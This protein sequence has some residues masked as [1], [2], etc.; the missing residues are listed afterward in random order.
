MKKIFPIL[1]NSFELN[2]DCFLIINSKVPLPLTVTKKHYDHCL[3]P[4]ILCFFRPF[5]LL[6]GDK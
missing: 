1:I 5:R 3:F 4:A 2:F 6:I